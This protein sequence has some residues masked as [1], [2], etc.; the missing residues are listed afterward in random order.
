[1]RFDRGRIFRYQ[2]LE[3][4]L[5]YL[6][7]RP[8]RS[9][10]AF[11]IAGEALGES[12]LIL[13]VKDK[14]P[15]HA[16][17]TF[18][19][20]GTKLTHR[21]RHGLNLT[22]NNF[23][24][25]DDVLNANLTLAEQGS[26]DGGSFYY[27]VPFEN[28]PA[29]WT[30]SGGYVKT[31]LIKHLSSAEIKGESFSLSPGFEYDLI[32][33]PEKTV[34]LALGVDFVNSISRINDVQTSADRVRTLHLGPRV[35]VQDMGGR[36]IF[37]SDIHVGIP[38]FLGGLKENDR[39][40][41]IVNTGGDYLFYTASAARYQKLPASMFLLMRVNG[42]W[43]RDSLPSPEQFRAGGSSS[44]RGYPESDAGGD[45]GWGGGAEINFPV[46]GLPKKW[47]IPYTKKTWQEAFRLTGFVDVAKTYLREKSS[48][49]SVKDKFLLGAG[50]G[51][52]F[53]MEDTLSANADLGWPLGD[54]SNDENNGQ[55]HLSMRGG[56]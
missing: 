28:I 5:Y 22:H 24:G 54:D 14:N 47:L 30:L 1:M 44:V 51:L 9:A 12:D 13:K 33:R 36:S 32:R 49:S 8:D 43:T 38:G 50:F 25:F 34:S 55:L 53:A 15:F 2:D 3:Q 39:N 19:N 18:S 4:S 52:R 46:P 48:E 41:S 42:Q 31:I 26:F 27:D 40:A 20:R 21:A 35:A 11:L 29:H 37:N 23:L 16:A 17:Y 7:R 6:N 45:Y 56:F 10:K